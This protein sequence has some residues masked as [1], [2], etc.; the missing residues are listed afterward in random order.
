MSDLWAPMLN[1]QLW[2]MKKNSIRLYLPMFYCDCLFLIM[3]VNINNK[4]D[5]HT[6]WNV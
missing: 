4:R 2:S 5:D 1:I 6:V 3:A